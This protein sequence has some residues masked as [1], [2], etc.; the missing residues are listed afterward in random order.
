MK[1]ILFI[2][3][4]SNFGG[5]GVACLN[6]VR[7]IDKQKSNLTVLT[8]YGNGEIYDQLI[9]E[10]FNAIKEEGVP[11]TYCHFSGGEKS[12]FS[13]S[14]WANVYRI[15]CCKSVI[16]RIICEIKPEVVV[17]NSMT[18]SWVGKLTKKIDKRI[19]TYCFHRET[20][21]RGLFGLRTYLLQRELDTYFERIAFISRYDLEQ[22][23]TKKA[24]KYYIPDCIDIERFQNISKESSLIE[25]SL[26]RNKTNIL[27]LGGISR[28]KGTSIAMR[29]VDLLP[30]N[31]V[32]LIVL[33]GDKLLASGMSN[34]EREIEKVYKEL[35]HPDRIL[36]KP[37]SKNVEVYYSACDI[38]VFPAIEPHQ[39]MPIFEAGIAKRPIIVSDFACIKEYLINGKNGYTFTSGDSSKLAERICYVMD[40]YE[41]DLLKGVVETNYKMAIEIHNKSLYEKNVRDFFDD[42]NED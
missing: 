27:F 10:G 5:S 6:I 19:D 37:A 12:V 25:T 14:Y 38:V 16:K 21:V 40:N 3:H 42:E 13:P 1:K 4:G 31:D 7:A 39:A 28:L 8:A 18:L 33:N 11:V 23:I 2:N 29:A 32:C 35:K 17:V 22:T 9:S 20:Y 36:L 41:T 15:C 34:E 30:S 24:K 26:D